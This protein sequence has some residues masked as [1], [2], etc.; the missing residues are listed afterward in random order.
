MAFPSTNKIYVIDANA[1]TDVHNMTSFASIAGTG[2][3]ISSMLICR[4]F[5]NSSHAD[6]TFTGKSAY[7]LEFDLHF[8]VDTM[9]SRT[10]TA[11]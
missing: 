11:K 10:E 7:L 3:N 2:K 6:D 5:R 9:G 4:L 8:E 1:A